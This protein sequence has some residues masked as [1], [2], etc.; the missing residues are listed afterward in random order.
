VRPTFRSVDYE[1]YRAVNAKFADA[2]VEEANT[3]DPVVLVQDYHF[4]LLPRMIRDRLPD[5]TIITFWHI[6][7]PNPEAFAICPW[8]TELLDGMLGSDIVGFQTAEDACNFAECARSLLRASVDPHGNIDYRRRSTQVGVYPAGVE[9]DTAAVHSLPPAPVCR[10]HVLRDFDLHQDVWL[11][12]GVD[13]LD[14]TKGLTEKFL[15]IERALE[16]H[17]FLR[18]RFAFIQV[19]EPGR[20]D[21]PGYREARARLH[22]TTARINGRFGTTS[23]TP[24]RLLEAHHEAT[25]L[26]R[27]YR[28]ANICYVGSL[29][30]G[31]NLTAKEFVCARHDER[32]VLMLSEFAGAAQQLKTAVLVNPYAVDETAEALARACTKSDAEQGGRMRLLRA[33]VRAF[34]ARWWAARLLADARTVRQPAPAIPAPLPLTSSGVHA[35]VAF[36]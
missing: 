31:M 3:K 2:V 29:H 8:R 1:T 32:G 26:Y 18:G 14:Y 11:G 7:W 12:I 4:A 5:A 6:P 27:L 28:A 15:A 30:D 20:D 33:N 36:M 13:R 10:V 22:D 23:Y 19:A 9:W 17:A 34:D 24:I 21:L 35:D 16:R 25:E